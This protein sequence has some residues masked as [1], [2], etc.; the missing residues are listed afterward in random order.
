MPVFREVENWTESNAVVNEGTNYTVTTSYG[1]TS[2]SV[3]LPGAGTYL[4]LSSLTYRAQVSAGIGAIDIRLYNTTD[5]AAVSASERRLGVVSGSDK[6]NWATA[7]HFWAV[8]VTGAKT[9]RIE[10][11]KTTV[12]APTWT[13]ATVTGVYKH[14]AYVKLST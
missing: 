13:V 12:S 3:S 8:A 5:A 4:I 9:I 14:M 1:D 11:T 7:S 6:T 2:I 10:A